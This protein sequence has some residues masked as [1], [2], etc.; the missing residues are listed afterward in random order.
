MAHVNIGLWEALRDGETSIPF[1]FEN[2]DDSKPD[3]T[4]AT[5]KCRIK[6]SEYATAELAE[7]SIDSTK[8]VLATGYVVFTFGPD[9]SGGELDFDAGFYPLGAELTEQGKSAYHFAVGIFRLKKNVT[10][11][12]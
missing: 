1:Q 2:A 9:V 10:D 8:S 3:L 6:E 7:A 5:G 4:N 12:T 11:V